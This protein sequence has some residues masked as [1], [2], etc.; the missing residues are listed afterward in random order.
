VVALAAKLLLVAGT[1]SAIAW[2]W[3]AD[4]GA[5]WWRDEGREA[6][7]CFFNLEGDA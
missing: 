6:L 4:V 1:L 5:A 7:A 2:V 3:W